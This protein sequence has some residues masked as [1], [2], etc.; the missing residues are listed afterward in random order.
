MFMAEE[1]AAR[2]RRVVRLLKCMLMVIMCDG[3]CDATTMDI[4]MCLGD[5]A[6]V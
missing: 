2:A 3:A 6:V 1:N 4:Q 5:G